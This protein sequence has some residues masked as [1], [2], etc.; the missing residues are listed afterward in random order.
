M[1][2]WAAIRDKLRPVLS[3]IYAKVPRGGRFVLGLLLM[4]GGLF[5]FLPILGFWMLPLGIMV[6]SFDVRLFWRWWSLRRRNNR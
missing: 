1:I 6:A 3:R 4:V 5:G 2:R